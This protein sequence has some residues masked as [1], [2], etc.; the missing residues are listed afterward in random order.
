MQYLLG[1]IHD[2]SQYM[3]VNVE[4]YFNLNTSINRL[5]GAIEKMANSFLRSRADAQMYDRDR[6]AF[7]FE[8]D[9]L[10]YQISTD[11]IKQTEKQNAK[12][13]LA[14]GGRGHM[15]D[16]FDRLYDDGIKT[17]YASRDEA[18]KGINEAT[19]MLL[20][21]GIRPT[22]ATMKEYLKSIN[23]AAGVSEMGNDEMQ[24]LVQELMNSEATQSALISA[25]AEQRQAIL[26]NKIAFIQQQKLQGLTTEQMKLLHDEL[27]KTRTGPAKERYKNAVKMQAYMSMHGI[28]GGEDIARIMMKTNRSKEETDRLAAVQKQIGNMAAGII[29]SADATGNIG[30]MFLEEAV[31]S[32]LLGKETMSELAKFSTNISDVGRAHEEYGDQLS[33]L[34]ERTQNVSDSMLDL[35]TSLQQRAGS[36]MSNPLVA[37]ATGAAGVLGMRYL[38]DRAG[39]GKGGDKKG[40]MLSRIFGAAKD[41]SPLDK[42]APN[43]SRLANLGGK[44][45][46]IGRTALM[47]ARLFTPIGLA[48]TLALGAY[49]AYSQYQQNKA[50][51]DPTGFSGAAAHQKLSDINTNGA[52]AAAATE[53]VA[54]LTKTLVSHVGIIKDSVMAATAKNYLAVGAPNTPPRS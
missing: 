28:A 14:E 29:A 7:Q 22:D 3:K 38:F 8:V 33:V 21:L 41:A 39:A 24:K 5:T 34:A 40:G 6:S 46:T 26:S 17:M 36:I 4:S 16:R 53:S 50:A 12:L 52:R 20:N 30:S 42:A 37:G 35:G 10:A 47:G 19:S 2:I 32:K 9:A 51:A 15:L 11:V 49:S 18:F 27:E 43:A 13:L 45:S 54:S 25:T 48:S 23:Y 31:S 44:L 1:P